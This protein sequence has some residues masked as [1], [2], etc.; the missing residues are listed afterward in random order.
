ML[1]CNL[2]IKNTDPENKERPKISEIHSDLGRSHFDHLE[3]I[4]ECC[5]K[6][7]WI[8]IDVINALFIFFIK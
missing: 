2:A 3:F 7:S 5:G 6:V 4:S 8:A 1:F